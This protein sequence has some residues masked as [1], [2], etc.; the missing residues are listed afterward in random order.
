MRKNKLRILFIA[1]T[2]IVITACDINQTPNYSKWVRVS[3]TALEDTFYVGLYLEENAPID[4]DFLKRSLITVNGTDVPFKFSLFDSVHFEQAAFTASPGDLI[5]MKLIH[6]EMT[7]VTIHITMPSSV[8]GAELSGPVADFLSGANNTIQMTW[9]SN[10]ADVILPW[11][12][13]YD[14]SGSHLL[15]TATHSSGTSYT[16]AQDDLFTSSGE[17]ASSI[18]FSIQA[19][20]TVDI[21]P[22]AEHSEL[23]AESPE[24]AV[25]N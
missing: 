11:I 15:S 19:M 6:D 20:N 8:S 7:D 10:P 18:T 2:F 4:M 5:T 25:T 13:L 9:N 17:K 14:G 21:K 12:N 16:F 22:Y 3:A 23:R 24:N 1:V